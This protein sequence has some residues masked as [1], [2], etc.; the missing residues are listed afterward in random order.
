MANGGIIGP[1]NDPII[2][3]D[4]V[5]PFTAS[6]CF[7]ARTGQPSVTILVVAGGGS[8]GTQSGGGGGAG[9]LR[10]ISCQPVSSSA[11]PI[12][13]GGGGAGRGGP[14]HGGPFEA[15]GTRG[16]DSSFGSPGNPNY[17]LSSGGGAGV[18]QTTVSQVPGVYGAG[19]S[20]GGGSS[21]TPA[22]F[23][24]G[25]TPPTSP[26]QGNPG[27]I[28]NSNLTPNGH[29]F[30]AG[31]G[32]SGGAAANNSI[33]TQATPG[34]PGTDVTS[35]FGTAP[36]PFYGPTSGVYAGGGGGSFDTRSPGSVGTGGPGG[37]TAGVGPGNSNAAGANTGG[38]SGGG[39]Y[40]PGGSGGSGNAGPGIVLIK[41]PAFTSISGVW[42]LQEQYNLKKNGQWTSKY[43][44]SF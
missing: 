27:G 41:E 38:G 9:G 22:P 35:T 23:V 19:G 3:S 28:G 6:G 39:A 37:G 2:E 32:G 24:V 16:T 21:S 40:G 17:I 13:I 43:D 42:S 44:L 20:G 8:G 25:N 10:L 1:V 18:Q 14:L 31:G 4:L 11:I 15:P 5:T 36:Q 7:T 12:V 30:G 34:G 29:T 33:T 26:P